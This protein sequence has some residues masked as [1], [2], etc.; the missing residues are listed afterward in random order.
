MGLGNASDIWRGWIGQGSLHLSL[1]GGTRRP[2]TRHEHHHVSAARRRR[3]RQ[4]V[5]MSVWVDEVD[6]MHKQ[7][8]AAG[9]EVTFPPTNMPWNVREMHLRHPDGHVFRVGRGFEPEK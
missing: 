6:E 5:W 3:G 1:S 9:L 4:S 2:R 8:V 7:C